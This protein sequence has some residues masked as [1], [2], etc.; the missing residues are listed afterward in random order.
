MKI[1]I[2]GVTISRKIQKKKT[3]TTT[4]NKRLPIYTG[5]F[6]ADAFRVFFLFW[7][8]QEKTEEEN[9]N[10]NNNNIYLISVCMNLSCE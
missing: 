10:N 8:L 1:F 7:F 4:T 2:D 3:T 5:C 9:N 6:L